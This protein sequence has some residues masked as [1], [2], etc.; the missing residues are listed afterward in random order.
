MHGGEFLLKRIDSI[1]LALR[2][3]VLIGPWVDWMPTAH[4][5]QNHA[6][7]NLNVQ[8]L[9]VDFLLTRL[10]ILLVLVQHEL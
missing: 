6:L 1:L 2:L 5:C 4:I 10:V 8:A 3:I 9:P 7:Q